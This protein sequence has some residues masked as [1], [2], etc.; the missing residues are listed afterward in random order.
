MKNIFLYLFACLLLISCGGDDEENISQEEIDKALAIS[1]YNPIILETGGIKLTEFTDFPTFSDVTT[2]ISS[3]NQTFKLGINK[4]EFKNEL[5]NLGQ[6]TAEEEK[7]NVRLNEGGQYLGILTPSG[8][9]TKVISSDFETDILKGTNLFLC[10]LSRSYDV[11]LKN[12]EASFLFKVNADPSGCFSETNLAD[13]VVA[14]LQPRG[15]YEPTIQNKIL[16]DFYLKNVDLSNGNFVELT[17]DKSV[18]KIT[19]WAPFWI[20]GLTQGT[21]SVKIDLKNK[22]GKSIKGIMPNQL[23]SVITLNRVEIFSE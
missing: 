6:K 11:S 23:S 12:K 19:K 2:K 14:L 13:T 9:V 7:H 20:S 1:N 8:E 22:E 16:F 18:F 4:I 3:Q 10:Y 17:I 5:F 21:H 15:S